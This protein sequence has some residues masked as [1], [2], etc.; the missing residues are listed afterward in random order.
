MRV[1]LNWGLVL[2]L[3]H[4]YTNIGYSQD[5]TTDSVR[6]L[7]NKLSQENIYLYQ[8]DHINEINFWIQSIY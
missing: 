8:N 5:P 2:I 6:V 3:I 4:F 7:F 1:K